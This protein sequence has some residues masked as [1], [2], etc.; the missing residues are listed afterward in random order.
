M[1]ISFVD[2]VV[3]SLEGFPYCESE[4]VVTFAAKCF[5]TESLAIRFMVRNTP[6]RK[7]DDFFVPWMLSKIHVIDCV[8]IVIDASAV[9][10]LDVTLKKWMVSLLKNGKKTSDIVV[11]ALPGTKQ[12]KNQFFDSLTV[13]V[14]ETHGWSVVRPRDFPAYLF[15][16]TDVTNQIRFPSH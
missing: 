9:P 7:Q 4:D 14:G 5:V 8:A 10:N 16:K 2:G 11:I 13:C 3:R 15:T 1:T 6:H 12:E